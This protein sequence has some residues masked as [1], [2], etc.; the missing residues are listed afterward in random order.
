M[1]KTNSQ[2]QWTQC[3]IDNLKV[4][5]QMTYNQIQWYKDE[6]EQR[7]KEKLRKKEFL[8]ILYI[9]YDIGWRIYFKQNNVGVNSYII[10]NCFCNTFYKGLKI[11]KNTLW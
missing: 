1:Q 5:E 9:N 2:M 10:S 7:E 4:I 11:K 3:H 8:I 6:M